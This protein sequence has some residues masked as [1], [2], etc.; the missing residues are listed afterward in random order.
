MSALALLAAL[1]L[2][3]ATA[4]AESDTSCVACHGKLGGGPAKHVGFA[5]G[6]CRD[7]HASGTE[8]GGCTATRK[9]WTVRLDAARV[10]Q[11]CHAQAMV[12]P[13]GSG[14]HTPV[15]SGQCLDCHSAHPGN[16]AHL[17]KLEGKEL[18]LSCHGP[19]GS[20]KV[21][22]DPKAKGAHA[23]L[24]SGGCL[25]CHVSS[26]S[27]K[28]DKLLAAKPP[29]VCYGCHEREADLRHAPVKEGRCTECHDPHQSAN[30]GLLREAD[31][32]LCLMC[33]QGGGA[34]QTRIDL[35]KPSIH[36]PVAGGTCTD[37]HAEGHGGSKP[38]LLVKAPPA[39]CYTCH[40]KP[41]PK[42]KIHAAVKMGQCTGCHDPH[43]GEA[44]LIRSAS[45]IC[46]ECHEIAKLAPGEEKHA[47]VVEGRCLECHQGHKSKHRLLLKAD[48]DAL[49]LSCHEKGAPKGKGRPRE[50][51]RVDL[52][53]PVIH[54]ALKSGCSGCHETGHSGNQPKLLLRRVD[55]LCAICHERKDKDRYTHGAVK[56]GDCSVCHDPHTAKDKNLLRM[57]DPK[58]SCFACH[59]DDLQGKSVVHRP[60]K[61]DGCSA[62]HGSHGGPFPNSL[63][64]KGKKLCYECHDPVDEG[65]VRHA[66]VDRKGCTVCHDAHASNT[67]GMLAKP[68]NDLCSSCHVDQS[69]GLHVS[70]S[71]H[72]VAGGRDPRDVEREFSCI[73]CHEP[74]AGKSPKLLFFGESPA[75]VCD[76]CHGDRTGKRPELKDI[77]KKFRAGVERKPGEQVP[78]QPQ[79]PVVMPEVGPGGSPAVILR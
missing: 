78:G 75:D 38:K 3:S 6:G 25:D 41:G 29:E 56:S 57:A 48:G 51:G 62:C 18:C 37:C 12:A 19:K 44:K 63:K 61:K 36:A 54:T 8:A 9:K 24:R 22:V 65:P 50:E 39:L 17:L 4:R 69:D 15:K 77:T 33:H 55:K 53:A 5:T 30:K 74:H 49:C 42:E 16:G 43:A 14:L 7:C 68:I 71:G 1:L 66:V 64:E 2:S 23:V 79:G 40:D 20:A 67:K 34:I 46:T 58:Q 59:A 76:G 26:H 73:S 10:C 35:N 70:S 13:T 31:A 27:A 11:N 52:K 47:P 60:V 21:K 45:G 72:V 28:N 32:K